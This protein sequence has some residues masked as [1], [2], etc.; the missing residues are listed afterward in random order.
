VIRIPLPTPR[1]SLTLFGKPRP[2]F[3]VCGYTGF[4][5]AFV[6]SSLLVA[7]LG[8][9]ELTLWGITGVIILTFFGLTM[10]TKVIAG[11]EL[12]IYYHHEIAVIVTVFAFLRATG[13]PALP[14]LDVVMLGLGLFLAF[15][16]VGCL[17]AGCCHGR[18]WRW[19]VI[20]GHE[21]LE[22]GFPEHLAG[23]RLLPIQLIEAAFALSIV[24]V[25]LASILAGYPSGTAFTL[26]VLVYAVGRFCF[27][28]VRGDDGRPCLW[29]FSEAQWTSSIIAMVEVGAER[30]HLIPS[31]GWH[32]AV[33][34]PVLAA[35]LALGLARRAGRLS[36]LDLLRPEHIREIAEAIQLLKRLVGPDRAVP[37]MCGPVPGTIQVAHT[38]LGLRI[39]VGDF[40]QGHRCARHY[41]ISQELAPL[42]PTSALVLAKTIGCL[43]HPSSPF[44]LVSTD[45]GMFHVIFA[46]DQH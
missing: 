14:Y 44:E 41:G 26:Y 6:Q 32:V 35:V 36:R 33:P 7:Y 17:M 23:V 25:G 40:A 29:G 18:P 9:S 20:Y 21:H 1:P 27:E 19:G 46:K 43:Q 3:Q 13:Q 34:L 5:L 4:F 39:S 37:S 22:E 16:R 10:I 15:G 45:S 38:S 2:S 42:S 28:F 31:H 11:Q 8:L 12:I 30:A 24:G